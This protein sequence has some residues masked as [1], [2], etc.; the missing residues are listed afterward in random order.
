MRNIIAGALTLLCGAA[1]LATITATNQQQ[2][3]AGTF[4]MC[5]SAVLAIV[6]LKTSER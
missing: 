4:I 5:I 3:I 6:I 1:M 2:V